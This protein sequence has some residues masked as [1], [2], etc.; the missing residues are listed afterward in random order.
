MFEHLLLIVEDDRWMYGLYG[1]T[2]ARCLRSGPSIRIF[3][4]A[5]Q[6]RV[7]QRLS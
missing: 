2:S 7:A 6:L 3:F 4:G 5:T 1:A